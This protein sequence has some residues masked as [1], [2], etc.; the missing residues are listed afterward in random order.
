MTQSS[1]DFMDETAVRKPKPYVPRPYQV[2]ADECIASALSLADMAGLY[3]ATGTGK[4]EIAAL[5]LQ[6]EWSGKGALFIAP[7]REL[8][9]QSADRL[10]L[11]GVNCGIEMAERRSEERVTVA[12]YLS[13]QSRKRYQRFLG[14]VGLIVVD[15][16]HMNYSPSALEMLAE[17]RSWGAK[18][19]GMTASPP[20]NRKHPLHE[21]YGEPAFVYSYQQ[22]VAEGY[23]VSCKTHL[24][25]LEDLDLSGFKASF[26]GYD[27][28][29]DQRRVDRLMQTKANVAGVGNM[30]EQFWDGK[31]SVVFCSS[32]A[33]AE[34][35]RDD[36][37]SRGI[38]AS[39]VHSEMDPDE[40]RLHL[41]D[42]MS[43]K[44]QVIVNVGILTMGWDAPHV[45][46]LFVARCTASSCLY[47]QMFGRGTRCLPG[48]ID[49]IN[50]V[51]GRLDAIARSQ[52][53]LF[54]VYDISDS[55]R[56]N[57]LKTA[58]DVLHPSLDDRMMKRVRNR[59]ARGPV[60]KEEIDQI[61]AEE[62][63][64]L[65]AE[66][67]AADRIEMQKRLHIAVGGT[68]KAYERDTFADA[69]VAHR[70]KVTDYWWM[71]Y[72]RFKGRGFKAIHA[73]APWYLP[74][75]LPHVK[76]E[77]LKRNIRKFLS[78]V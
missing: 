60:T 53:P 23:L 29:F 5:L 68:V 43:G 10:T 37:W 33:H 72:G 20:T 28:D 26:G 16:S 9:V 21:H 78:A 66:Q 4:T 36:L 39:I 77:G 54:E 48:V 69:E 32:I 12:C 22:A 2:E 44:T 1:M 42:F 31:P 75:V 14:T 74:S 24:C 27:K 50:T 46:K 67:A 73:Q 40:Q 47:T 58:L 76:D 13:L 63:R 61:V 8:V 11:R 64:A 59:T 52:K 70:K 65:A 35:V 3:L 7:R 45:C 18:V 49:G 71:P 34:A 15:E 55:S 38:C 56:H 51:E 19:V 57:D 30:V 17:F 62:Q 25:V 41:S 6:R